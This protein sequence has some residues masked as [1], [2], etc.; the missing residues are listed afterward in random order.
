MV[1]DTFHVRSS[2]K[3]KSLCFVTP[4]HTY[5]NDLQHL[6]SWY[7][8]KGMIEASEIGEYDVLHN[9]YNCHTFCL[10]E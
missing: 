5:R 6:L 8:Y 7:S 4:E 10:A 9:Y 3:K 2:E 1:Q